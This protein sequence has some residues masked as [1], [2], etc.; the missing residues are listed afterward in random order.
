M[1]FTLQSDDGDVDDANAYISVAFFKDYHD[2]RGNDYGSASDAVIQVWIVNATDYIDNRWRAVFKGTILTEAQSTEWPRDNVVDDRGDDVEGLPRPLKRAC[3]EYALRQ[4]DGDLLQDG[5]RG[6]V[7]GEVVANGTIT[8]KTETVGPVTESTT[9]AEHTS[10][11]GGTSTA[12]AALLPEIPAA[13]LL[14]ERLITR[15]GNVVRSYR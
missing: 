5:V 11:A 8:S 2:E 10:N 4:K 15:A 13:D 1:A 9:Y 3:A 7:D 6:V 14:M 12:D